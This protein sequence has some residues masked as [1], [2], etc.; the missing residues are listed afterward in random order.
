MAEDLDDLLTER[1]AAY[2]QWLDSGQTPPADAGEANLPPL[3]H[4]R[5]QEQKRCLDLLHSLRDQRQ[6]E[7]PA[8]ASSVRHA[9][10]PGGRFQ[11]LNELGSGGFGIVWRARD[12]VTE[13]IV[14]LKVPRPEVLASTELRKRFEQEAAAVARLDHPNIVP[15]LEAGIDGVLPYI[16]STYYEGPTLAEWL[17]DRPQRVA[18]RMAAQLALTL[19]SALA[20]AHERGVLHRDVKPSNVLLAPLSDGATHELPFEPKLMDFGLAKLG[21]RDQELTRTGAMLG[22]LRYMAPEQAAGR[23]QEITAA[24]DVYGLGGV[25]YELLAGTPPFVGESDWLTLRQVLEDEPQS[26]VSLRQDVPRDLDVIVRK[27]LSKTPAQRYRSARD[28]A[29]DLERFLVGK[30][31]V[32]RPVSALERFAK[33]CRRNPAWAAMIAVVALSMVFGIAFLSY[34]N[35]R[36]SA[37][38]ASEHAVR[39]QLARRLYA[40]DMR[41]ADDAIKQNNLRHAQEILQRYDAPQGEPDLREF[42]WHFLQARLPKQREFTPRHPA[43]VYSLD[44]SPD[45]KLLATACADGRVRIWTPAG[46]LVRELSCEDAEPNEAAF[47][48]DGKWLAAACDDGL[49]RVW[50]TSGWSPRHVLPIGGV[51]TTSINDQAD[52]IRAIAVQENGSIVVAGSYTRAKDNP[53]PI[54]VRYK[55]NGVVDQSF[56]PNG[57]VVVWNTNKLDNANAIL[58][59]PGGKIVVAGYMGGSMIAVVRLNPDGSYDQTFGEN[60]TALPDLGS[61]RGQAHALARQP[62]G[63]YLLAGRVAHDGVYRAAIVRLLPNGEVDR[64]FGEGGV[65]ITQIGEFDG[66]LYSLAVQPDGKILAAGYTAFQRGTPKLTD[67]AVVRYNVDGSLDPTFH[68]DGILTLSLSE[69]DDNA[70]SVALQSDGKILVVGYGLFGEE[71]SALIARLNDNGSLD[72]TFAT[73]GIAKLDFGLETSLAR[74][75]GVQPDGKILV[76]GVTGK[77]V[78]R[79]F[80]VVRLNA[81]GSFD[82]AFGAKG[83]AR[84]HIGTLADLSAMTLCADGK[85]LAAGT[86]HCGGTSAVFGNFAMV[87]LLPNGSLDRTFGSNGA[88]GV[89]FTP[90]GK[91]VL[92]YAE[93]CVRFWDLDTGEIV[94]E[95]YVPH[96]SIESIDVSP[97]GT[98]LGTTSTHSGQ[99]WDIDNLVTPVKTLHSDATI[100]SLT[101]VTD[102]DEGV[103]AMGFHV[104]ELDIYNFT[105]ATYRYLRDSAGT[106]RPRIVHRSTDGRWLIAIS[107]NLVTFSRMGNFERVVELVAQSRV[108]DARLGPGG[109][110]ILAC[111]VAGEVLE[112]PF[113]AER[114]VA[115]GTAGRTLYVPPEGIALEVVTIDPDQKSLACGHSDGSI[116]LIDAT[117]GDGKTLIQP[118]GQENAIKGLGFIAPGQL[119]V[120]YSKGSIALIDLGHGTMREVRVLGHP[121][122]RLAI[123]RDGRQIAVSLDES[124]AVEILAT[125]DFEPVCRITHRGTGKQMAFSPSGQQIVIAGGG[126]LEV[127]ETA[128]GKSLAAESQPGNIYA[129]VQV[130]ADQ[131]RM[132]VAE[133]VN[134]FTLR[135]FPGARVLA[136][137]LGA[138]QDLNDVAASANGRNLASKGRDGGLRIW[139]MET[140]EPLLTL[141]SNID[142]DRPDGI[143]FSADGRRLFVYGA[144]SLMVWEAP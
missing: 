128:T 18:P 13:R 88:Q 59:E 95:T 64:A 62:D 39:E 72:E 69:G 33:W 99:M 58:V 143:F 3:L 51:I 36:I 23:V 49:V 12:P 30:A 93:Q 25:L 81:D 118:A 1:L 83:R 31:I 97:S 140:R 15:V 120:A 114:P 8:A 113:E 141:A 89:R 77:S 86:A 56:G 139:D 79:S 115:L 48:P 28:L 60:G 46:K 136:R 32:A 87:R 80:A 2:Q 27:C 45:E 78:Q 17:K 40:S 22:T 75:V 134:G 98:W 124:Q 65:R 91:H 9:A 52:R 103:I 127:F 133:G 137:M 50:E 11:R 131:A 74:A 35:V 132:V 119:V 73:A 14:A 129:S 47:S 55:A 85:I 106:R 142:D 94:K 68:E 29:D 116:R 84:I 38:L 10:W 54:V 67:F 125:S 19:A 41:R 43:P 21:E 42:A 101:F 53:D 108:F 90:D 5:L 71:L 144:W 76:A 117:T 16:A 26:L 96:G 82:P 111:T 34:S 57:D 61:A 24:S 105:K 112:W 130:F 4:Q 92:A 107:D 66:A 44:L 109:D 102:E 63:K 7:V 37:A 135:D 20:H 123:S 138:E 110:S 104:G 6:D 100:S 122:Q 70:S 126:H 121:I